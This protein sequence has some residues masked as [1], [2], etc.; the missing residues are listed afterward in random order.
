MYVTVVLDTT[1]DKVIL[2]RTIII[3]KSKKKNKTLIS[4]RQIIP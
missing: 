4:R 1:L 3:K 2:N